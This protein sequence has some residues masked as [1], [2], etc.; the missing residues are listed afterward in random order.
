MQRAAGS[1]AETFKRWKGAQMLHYSQLIPSVS[2]Q[3]LAGLFEQ[4]WPQVFPKHLCRDKQ[5]L[6]TH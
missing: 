5:V 2:T 4:D 6:Q 1:A 3:S